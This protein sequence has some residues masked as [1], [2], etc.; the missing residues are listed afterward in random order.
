MLRDGRL[1]ERSANAARQFQ[2]IVV[3]PEMDEEHPRLFVEH[4]TV[5]RRHL[6]IAGS[7]RPDQRIDLIARYQK[8]AGDG[9]LAVAGRLKIDG[10]SAAKRSTDRHAAFPGRIAPGNAELIDTA[11]GGFLPP[12]RLSRLSGIESGW[13]VGAGARCP[14]ALAPSSLPLPIPTPP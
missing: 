12:P 9:S 7:Q 6:D 1:V 5:D 4:V 3:R 8:I 2:G 10:V 11:I 14:A 13:G